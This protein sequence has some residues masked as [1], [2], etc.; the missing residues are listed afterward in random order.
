M[1]YVIQ[2]PGRVLHIRKQRRNTEEERMT[3]NTSLAGY[4][5]ETAGGLV[6]MW[7]GATLDTLEADAAARASQRTIPS[8]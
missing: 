7:A 4:E 1:A 2:R 8:I 5:P 3:E 6:A